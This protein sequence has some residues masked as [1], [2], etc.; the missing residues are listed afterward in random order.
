MAHI[1]EESGLRPTRRHRFVASD[2]K[3]VHHL[4]KLGFALLD[5]R[6][7]G[8]GGDRPTFPGAVLAYSQPSAVGELL[9]KY[10]RRLMVQCDAPFGPCPRIADRR[11]VVPAML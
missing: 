8:P 7:V 1:G 11:I 10:R 3:V 5:R 9:I 2:F 6:D 4:G